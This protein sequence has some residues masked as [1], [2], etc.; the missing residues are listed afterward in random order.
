MRNRFRKVLLI[1][2]DISVYQLLTD[3]KDIRHISSVSQIFPSIFELSP[4]LI[5]FDY[6]HVSKDMERIVRRIRANRFYNNI[7]LYCYKT[8]ANEKTDSLLKAIGVD[9]VIYEQ[10]LRKAPKSKTVLNTIDAM[11]DAPLVKWVAN[12]AHN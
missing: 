3:H 6:E 10:D 5:V 4:N 11:L 2:P 1:A 8:R 12:V 7:K 9:E